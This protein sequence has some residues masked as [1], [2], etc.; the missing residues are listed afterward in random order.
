MKK[1][2]RLAVLLLALGSVILAAPCA[3]AGKVDDVKKAVKEKCNA[4][5]ADADTV[6]AV[7]KAYDC[8]PG[9][10]VKVGSCTIKCLKGGGGNVVGGK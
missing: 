6:D 9:A 5:L 8:N 7:L 10:D 2:V 4:D 3:F 1:N